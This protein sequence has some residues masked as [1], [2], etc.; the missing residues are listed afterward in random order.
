VLVRKFIQGAGIDQPISMIDVEHS[1]AT[2]YYH[3]DALGSVV[4]LSNASGSTVEVYEYSVFGEVAASDT[5]NP[6]PFMFTGRE[7][8]KETGLYFYRARYYAPEIGRFLQT[9]PIGYGDSMDLYQYCV[10]NPVGL[11][12]PS[13]TIISWDTAQTIL[14]DIHKSL[15]PAYGWYNEWYTQANI[16]SIMANLTSTYQANYDA[17]KPGATTA[18][19]WDNAAAFQSDVLNTIKGNYGLPGYDADGNPVAWTAPALP[20]DPAGNCGCGE[21]LEKCLW[22]QLGIG[23][24]GDGLGDLARIIGDIGI[25]PVVKERENVLGA[26]AGKLIRKLLQTGKYTNVTHSL[27]NKMGWRHLGRLLGRLNLPISLGIMVWDAYK[28]G[29]CTAD[30]MKHPCE[31]W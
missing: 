14:N 5:T 7:F 13:G 12:D 23:D 17:Q 24:I 3:Y 16:D 1:S 18:P 10:N 2:Y 15:V 9:D 8:D 26:G 25:W 28:I 11:T 21:C 6:N 30:C 22:K 19:W 27:L 31:S 4:A 29:T 20:P